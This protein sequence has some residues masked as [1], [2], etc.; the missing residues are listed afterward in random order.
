[1]RLFWH[2]LSRRSVEVFVPTKA[3]VQ[4]QAAVDFPVVLAIET[5]LLGG[6]EETRIAVGMRHADHSAGSSKALRIVHG[7]GRDGA[8]IIGEVDFES[9]AELEEAA[10]DGV[11]DVVDASFESVIAESFGDV[12][13]ELP[14]ALERLLRNVGVGAERSAREDD[15]R[16]ADVAGNQVVPILDSRSVNWFTILLERMELRVKLA[17]WRWFTVKLPLVRS[18]VPSD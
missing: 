7:I 18:P 11:P 5:K 16:S 3:E 8:G 17:S 15:Q 10:F 9:R 4:S 13:L 6:D 12:V 14:F 2:C 1:M